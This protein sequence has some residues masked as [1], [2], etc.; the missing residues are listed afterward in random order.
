M[1]TFCPTGRMSD[2]LLTPDYRKLFTQKQYYSRKN[3]DL[4]KNPQFYV[5]AK[6]R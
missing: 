5:E 6:L 3:A 4:H 2:L 1:W